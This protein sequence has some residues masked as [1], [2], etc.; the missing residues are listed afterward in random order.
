M[1]KR[2]TTCR[3]CLCAAIL[4][5]LFAGSIAK[6]QSQPVAAV[7]PKNRLKQEGWVFPGDPDPALPFVPKHPDTA[8]DKKRRESLAWFMTGQISERRN[9]FRGAYDAYRKSIELE[10]KAVEV[11]RSL[12][13]LALAMNRTADA[14]KYA[15]KAVELDPDDYL[16]ARRLAIFMAQQRNIPEAIKLLKIAAK[17]K[18]LKKFT[19]ANVTIQRDL[20]IMYT[21]VGKKKE[22]ADAFLTV[23]RARQDPKKYHLD[24]ATRQRLQQSD[25]TSF[26]RMGQVFLDDNRPKLAIEA[27]QAAQKDAKG[28][29]GSLNFNLA[30]VYFQTKQND[31]ALKELQKY[32]D[33]QLQT[34]G[35]AAYQLLADILKAQK[36]SGELLGR[37]ETLAKLDRNN[38]T[39]Q[40]YLADQYVAAGKLKKAEALYVKTMAGSDDPKALLGLATIYRRQKRSDK[41]LE[42]LQRGLRGV[43]T[44]DDLE[45][46]LPRV[47]T[48]VKLAA[49]DKKLL[50]RLIDDGRRAAAAKPPKLKFEESLVLAKV[51]A[52]A[53]DTKATVQF[54]RFALGARPGAASVLFGELGTYLLTAEDYKQAAKVFREAAED[55][56]LRSSRPN[57]LFRLSQAEELAGNTDAA[58][59]AVR[60]AQKELPG[61]GLLHYQEAW[62]HYHARKWKTAIGMFEKV[63]K[64]YPTNREIV[65]RCRFSLSNIYVQQGDRKKG[66]DILWQV[67]KEDPEDIS[68]N[69]DLGYLLAESGRMLA[70]AESMIRKAVKAE[71]ENAAYLDS[72]GWVL[73]MRGKYQEALPNLKK[74]TVLP[75]GGDATIWDHLGDCQEKVKQHTDAVASWKKALDKARKSR[76]PDK[77]L[78]GKLRKKL[79]IT[80]PEPT[81]AAKPKS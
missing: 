11:Y 64:D 49:A 43:R 52:E 65:K 25:I 54:Y 55:S 1:L 46:S 60:V 6:A 13:P 56:A 17:A 3:P 20:A 37:L 34:K 78:I 16:L 30:K 75:N 68:V 10:P 70:K 73:Y 32:L 19:S 7:K 21:A 9:N 76:F 33:A 4:S 77:K 74:A 51:A 81:K 22:A 35:T 28:K 71:P 26:E 67:Y 63:I 14:I 47:E 45:N 57:F 23:F 69:N 80:E 8:A 50:K 36:K 59:K 40:Y 38:S 53:K 58:L 15:R 24:S 39:L 62:I 42:A 48:E 18:S 61:I 41:W 79:G 2:C 5:G 72:L 29:P 44:A 27:F 12:V 66:E 31:K